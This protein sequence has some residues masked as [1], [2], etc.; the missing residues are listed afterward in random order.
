MLFILSVFTYCAQIGSPTGG[1]KDEIP[2]TFLSSNPE[3]RATNFEGEEI[4]IEFNEYLTENLISKNLVVSPPMEEAPEIRLKNK[5]LQV[6]FKDTLKEQTTYTLSFGE[7]IADLNESNVLQNFE[8]VF[9]TGENIDSMRISGFVQ[10]AFDLKMEEEKDVWVMV[11]TNLNDSTPF[12]QKPDFIARANKTGYFSIPNIP[13]KPFRIL[14]LIDQ[15]SNLLFDLPSEMIAFS[16]SLINPFCEVELL[17]D[18]LQVVDSSLLDSLQT[19]LIDTILT[20]RDSIVIH[21]KTKFLPDSLQLFLFEEDYKIQRVTD[22]QRPQKGLLNMVLNK[23][24]DSTFQFRFLDSIPN[25]FTQHNASNDFIT[26]WITDSLLFLAD[27]VTII[28]EYK[29]TDSLNQLIQVAD[30]I[31]FP[32]NFE[33]NADIAEDTLILKSSVSQRFLD[34][35]QLPK[36]YFSHP[37]DSVVLERMKLSIKKDT[38][39]VP[40]PFELLQDSINSTLKYVKADFKETELY[41]LLLNDSTFIDYYGFTNDSV[42][43]EFS[44]REEGFY[45][46]LIFNFPNMNC[47]V[48]LQLYNSS[49]ALL[50]EYYA[51]VGEKIYLKYL[52]PNI[53]SLKLILDTNND[54]RWTTGNYLKAIL[55]EKV[56][57][58]ESQIEVK[59][60]WENEIEWVLPQ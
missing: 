34:F 30:T 3:M 20:T 12:L 13:Q 55:P 52:T 15:N 42:R 10:Y 40:I 48:I 7:G 27:S 6:I 31:F 58:Y 23:P 54:G 19:A 32:F 38:V 56:L 18:T 26:I 57:F 47:N 59:A 2:P 36:L 53:Y 14:A 45:G 41:E 33:R 11:Y 17:M 25:Y 49:N 16:D 24:Y 22:F 44:K 37:I 5:T 28:C 51:N 50:Q 1:A 8:F 9:S 35:H 29:K 46:G 39:F 43:Y 21:Q 4:S 60:G